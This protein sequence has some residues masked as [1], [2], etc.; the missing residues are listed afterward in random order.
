MKKN[1]LNKQIIIRR[2]S[3]ISLALVLIAALASLLWH[4]QEQS[5]EMRAQQ[6]E[7]MA[8]ILKQQLALAATM[9]LKLNDQQQLQWLAQTL[10]ESP[11]INGVWIH[12]SDGT[13]MAESTVQTQ[14]PTLM[15]AAEIRQ[16][17]LLGYLRLRLNQDV[18]V[19]PI[20][21]IQKQQ[22]EWQR[23]SLLLA[24]LI[25]ILLARALSQKRAKYQLRDLLNKYR[26][27][28]RSEQQEAN[29]ST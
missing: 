11:L 23:W 29:E 21:E 26:R 17:K 14:Q 19:Q 4:S 16:D 3:Q 2:L 1:S 6:E 28:E 5:K 9:G 25:G 10:S 24:G 22:Q 15:L 27:K 12:R 7:S 18:F 20:V 8:A 13:L